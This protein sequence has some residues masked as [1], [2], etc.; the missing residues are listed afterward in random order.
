MTMIGQVSRLWPID[1]THPASPPFVDDVIDWT[2]PIAN[3]NATTTTRLTGIVDHSVVP[4]RTGCVR[5]SPSPG[6]PCTHKG[7]IVPYRAL[8][9]ASLSL[10][11]AISSSYATAATATSTPAS[12]VPDRV[13][14]PTASIDWPADEGP[15]P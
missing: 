12:A 6:F 13:R 7:T 14:N 1:G 15:L 2:D 9:S 10:S 5:H 3:P 8:R 11:N 4:E